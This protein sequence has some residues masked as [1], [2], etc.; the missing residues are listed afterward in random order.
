M[1]VVERQDL[2]ADEVAEDA[3]RAEVLAKEP[4]VEQHVVG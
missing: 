3:T 1:E 2:T 4:M